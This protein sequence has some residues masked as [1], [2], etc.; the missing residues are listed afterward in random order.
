[1]TV[2]MVAGLAAANTSA[3][4]PWT[5]CWARVALEP[6]LNSTVTPG[7]ASLNVLPSSVKAPVSE[8]AANTVSFCA[9]PPA[10]G[11]D[12]VEAAPGSPAPHPGTRASRTGRARAQRSRRLDI[13]GDSLSV[14]GRVFEA[15]VSTTTLVDLTTAT[16]TTPGSR[17]SS[18]A[19]WRLISDTTRNGPA[20]ISTCAIT[21]SRITSVTIPRKRL[22]AEERPAPFSGVPV[23]ERAKAARSAPSTRRWPCSSRSAVSR[24]RPPTGARCRR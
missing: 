19:A 15:G 8:A 3:G 20:A 23:W 9:F 18:S 2:F 7:W 10:A 5:I 21:A 1:M 22:R 11:A 12:A 16:A 6:K 17:P 14:S 13:E 4:A 24:P